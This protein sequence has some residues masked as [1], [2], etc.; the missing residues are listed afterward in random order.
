V[1]ARHGWNGWRDWLGTEG[2]GRPAKRVWREYRR[3]SEWVQSLGL[4]S[5]SEWRRF[6]SSTGLPN[7]IP[8]APNI[9]YRDSGWVSWPEW[10]RGGSPL[11]RPSRFRPFDEARRWARDLRVSRMEDWTGLARA[12]GLPSDIPKTPQYV[13]AE[14]GWAGWGDWFGTGRPTPGTVS[15]RPFA[16]AREFVRALRIPDQRAY[17]TWVRGDTR[18]PDIPANP[19]QIYATSGWSGY[20]DWLGNGRASNPGKRELLPFTE[21]RDWARTWAAGMDNPSRQAFREAARK[22]LVPD[23][24]PRSPD[25]AYARTG[26]VSWP[27]WLGNAPRVRSGAVVRRGGAP[28][29]P[30]HYRPFDEAR[31]WVHRLQ[32]ASQ[33]EWRVF[34][35]SG[36]LPADIPAQPWRVYRDT[37]WRDTRDWL[38]IRVR[39]GISLIE[40]RLALELSAALGIRQDS[41]RITLIDG[42]RA[43]VDI[44]FRDLLLAIEFDGAFWHRN[45]EAQDRRKSDRLRASGWTVIRVREAPLSPLDAMD[46]CVPEGSDPVPLCTAVVERLLQTNRLPAAIA[47]RARRYRQEGVSWAGLADLREILQ[48]R[49]LPFEEAREWARGLGLTRQVE[50]AEYTASHELPKGI[51]ACPAQ[52]YEGV[53]WIS[54]GDWLGTGFVAFSSRQYRSFENARAWA[55]EAGFSSGGQWRRF[56]REGGLPNDIPRTPYLVYAD[57]GWSGWDDWLGLDR[58]NR[59]RPFALAREWA[60]AQRISSQRQWRALVA[61]GHLPPNIPCAPDSVYGEAWVSWMDWL[62]TTWAGSPGPRGA[63]LA[64]GQYRTFEEARTWARESGFSSGKKWLRFARDGGVP[65]DIPRAPHLVYADAGWSGWDDWLGLDRAGRVVMGVAA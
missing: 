59:W 54:L 35:A 45:K 27:D 18:P 47:E 2:R 61:K 57:S 1:Y 53:G 17:R 56:A 24:I 29:V 31:K 38:G 3:A 52:V 25:A 43:R 13:Y 41:S 46:V 26:W 7:D 39:H 65:S 28:R 8:S 36:A 42:K 16:A 33:K 15:W 10:L 32:L 6:I 4:K 23:N 60:Q 44:V 40:R 11:V 58:T 30:R 9:V 22:G 5:Q 51:P 20:G 48:E 64:G 19:N 62:G 49:W 63:G 37:G 34:A 50:W 12:G 14:Q 21:A 55:R